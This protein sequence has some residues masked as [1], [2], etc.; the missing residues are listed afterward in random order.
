MRVII[1]GGRSFTDRLAIAEAIDASG[2]SITECVCGGARGADM[3]G[4]LVCHEA[5]IPVRLFPADWDTFGKAAGP[6]RNR[7]MAEYADALIC[8]ALYIMRRSDENRRAI[9]KLLE[10]WRS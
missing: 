9:A 1:A 5:G 2:F 8:V 6:I 10:E 7:Q 3:L 4:A